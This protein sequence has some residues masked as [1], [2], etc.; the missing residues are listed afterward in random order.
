MTPRPV[1]PEFQYSLRCDLLFIKHTNTFGCKINNNV[2]T[3]TSISPW[4]NRSRQTEI[5][6]FTSSPGKIPPLSKLCQKRNQ[7]SH[8]LPAHNT[9]ATTFPQGEKPRVHSERTEGHIYS[10]PRSYPCSLA[11]IYHFCCETYLGKRCGNSLRATVPGLHTTIGGHPWS[12][13]SEG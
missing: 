1:F 9:T 4:L 5:F 12:V 8:L 6:Y 3:H 11:T 2:S 10:L 7:H 13:D